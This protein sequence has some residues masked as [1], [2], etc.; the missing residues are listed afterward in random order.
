ME[1]LQSATGAL[2][3][4]PSR[5]VS[6]IVP[7]LGGTHHHDQNRGRPRRDARCLYCTR[8]HGASAHLSRAYQPLTRD[9]SVWRFSLQQQL[10]T[11]SQPRICRHRCAFHSLS[12]LAVRNGRRPRPI[13]SMRDGRRL[14]PCQIKIA[15][16]ASGVMAARVGRNNPTGR[17]WAVGSGSLQAL[18]RPATLG[19]SLGGN[20]GGRV[21]RVVLFEANDEMINQRSHRRRKPTL[22]GEHQMDEAGLLAPV[23]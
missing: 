11:A 10:P 21:H 3:W 16:P 12:G 5:K 8:C 13:P 20:L 2:G 6:G 17:A 14:A 4:L 9:P 7:I 15:S 23:R 1:L 22:R 18:D 19:R